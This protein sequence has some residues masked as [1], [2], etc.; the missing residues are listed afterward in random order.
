MSKPTTLRR[1]TSPLLTLPAVVFFLVFAAVPM[2]VVVALSFTYYDTLNPPT[3]AGLANWR[4]IFHDP[5]TRHGTWLSLQVIVLSWLLQTPVAML[6]GVFLAG[7]QRYRGVYGAVFILPLLFS[8]AG[9]GIMWKLLLDPN[10]G[11]AVATSTELHAP[12]LNQ[13]WLGSQLALYV[14]IACIGW[15]FT[16]LHTLLY[17]AAARQIP[18]SLYEAAEI[19]GAGRIAQFRSITL[20]LMRNTIATSSTLLIVGSLT[21][22]DLI[23]VMTLGGPG[24]ATRILPM[25]MYLNG[26]ALRAAGYGS[27]VASVLVAAGVGLSI[28]ITRITGF[29]KMKSALEGAS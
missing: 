23:Y 5:A 7:K 14:I 18:R 29:S 13:Q 27:A 12:V 24:D 19:D 22:F 10:F 8:T 1:G 3:W 9:I 17:Q 21:Y 4:R 28:L 26:F 2:V 6:L 15:Q 25:D 16:P 11:L 20:P